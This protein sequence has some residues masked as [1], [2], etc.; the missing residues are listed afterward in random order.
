MAENN[1]Y[2]IEIVFPDEQEDSP[3]SSPKADSSADKGSS[4][5]TYWDK[6]ADSAK[7]AA[8]R[9]VSAATAYAVADELIS[10]ELSTVSLRTG[11]KEYE[12]KLQLSYSALK[13]TVV[14]LVVGATTGGLPGAI[15]GGLFGLGMQALTWAQNAQTIDY[16]RQ[17]ENISIDMARTRAGVSGSRSAKQ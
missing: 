17:L 13:Q 9:I 11:A 3:V 7:S 6:S 2:V 5:K 12:Q 14:P 10:Y 16:N 1:R 8:K 15:I 4:Q